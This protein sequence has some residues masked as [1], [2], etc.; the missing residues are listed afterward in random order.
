VKTIVDSHGGVVSASHNQ[1][2]GAV[3]SIELPA[4]KK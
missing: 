2:R 4:N 3:F 1:P